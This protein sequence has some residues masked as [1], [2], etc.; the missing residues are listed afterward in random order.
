MLI[1]KQMN[2]KN[3]IISPIKR[4]TES[5]SIVVRN[6]I[7]ELIQ[8]KVFVPGDKLPVEPE[9]AMSLGV[10]RGTLR[11][12]LRLLEEDGFISRRPGVGTFIRKMYADGASS[13]SLEKNFGALEVIRSM[14]LSPEI[15][16]VQTKVIKAD[17]VLSD[18]L[19]VAVGS[20]LVFMERVIG[21]KG[22]KIVHATNIVPEIFVTG[23]TLWNFE[24]SL[25]EFLEKRCHH[26]IGYAIAKI[27]PVTADGHLSRML[28]IN[29]GSLLLLIEQVT[30]TVE[31]EPITIAR[32][33]WVKDI[34]D[35]TIFRTRR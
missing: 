20:S 35:F 24:G 18:D 25:Y 4:P 19:K 26:E 9:L 14:G 13:N 10:S 8:E 16:Q 11:E 30:Y 5:L 34:V 27:I 33:Y 17:R 3:K 32:E 31:E 29:T 22:K 2:T 7:V 15:M 28:T 21:A 1:V 6:R 23:G 12:A